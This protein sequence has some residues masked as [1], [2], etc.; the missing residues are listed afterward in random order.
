MTEL[1]LLH[2]FLFCDINL[3]SI[4][5]MQLLLLSN[6]KYSNVYKNTKSFSKWIHSFWSFIYL[7][8]KEKLHRNLFSVLPR[9]WNY[10][11]QLSNAWRNRTL[12]ENH[13]KPLEYD[14]H[15]RFCQT[16]HAFDNN[17]KSFHVHDRGRMVTMLSYLKNFCII[18]LLE[19]IF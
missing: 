16:Y 3:V 9:F 14:N 7:S 17:T 1:I 15:T 19:K 10:N 4:R 8:Q 6:L 18:I 5:Y 12:T 13:G 2:L 11:V